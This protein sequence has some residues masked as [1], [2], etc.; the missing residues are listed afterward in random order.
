M[1]MVITFVSTGT[2]GMNIIYKSYVNSKVR[3]KHYQIA[4]FPSLWIVKFDCKCR[5]CLSN[6]DYLLEL[7]LHF[8]DNAIP[9]NIKCKVVIYRF[10]SSVLQQMYEHYGT[11]TTARFKL[12][13]PSLTVF[14]P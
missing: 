11:N 14:H 6:P 3:T 5:L 10:K 9:T 7:H 12:I 4:L 8:S 2:F 1:Y 13:I